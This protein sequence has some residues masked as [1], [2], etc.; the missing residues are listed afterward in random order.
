MLNWVDVKLGDLNGDG[1]PDLIGRNPANG[2]WTASLT[3]PAGGG[4]TQSYGS[5]PVANWVDVQFGDF[6]ADGKMDMAGRDAG[7]GQWF[8]SLSSGSTFTPLT[9]WTTWTPATTWVDVRSGRF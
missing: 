3:Q 5:W 6:N 8:V 2:A 7:T 1:L 4:L 9:L